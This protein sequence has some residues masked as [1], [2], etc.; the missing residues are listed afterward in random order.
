MK[1]ELNFIDVNEA[2][3]LDDIPEESHK[4]ILCD[5]LLAILEYDN[6]EPG[7]TLL[8][9]VPVNYSGKY[10]WCYDDCGTPHPKDFPYTVRKWARIPKLED[11]TI[12]VFLSGCCSRGTKGC[13]VEHEV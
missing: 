11:C 3:P 12:N 2:M 6:W 13:E 9:I 7:D 10:G 5:D 8:S 1:I 4:Y